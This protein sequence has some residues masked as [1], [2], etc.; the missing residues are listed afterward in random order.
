[1]SMLGKKNVP[2]FLTTVGEIRTFLGIL[3]LTG[4]NTLPTTRSYWSNQSTLGC[5]FVKNAMSRDRFEKINQ[6]LHVCD[7]TN[8]DA[9]DKFAKA[10]PLNNFLNKKFMQFGVFD[11]NL[12][13]DEQMIAYYGRHTLKIFISGK[14]IR[15]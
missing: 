2:G 14:P 9:S 12:S 1:M 15:V 6:N 7:N 13:I 8:L 11:H 4:Y 5:Q 3:Y 10:T